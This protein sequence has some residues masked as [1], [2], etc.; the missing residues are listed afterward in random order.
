MR[1]IDKADVARIAVGAAVL[2]TGGGGDPA[3]GRLMAEAAIDRYGPVQLIGVDEVPDDAWV[4]PSSGMGAPTVSIEKLPSWREID[5]S[6]DDAQVAL[7]AQPFATMPIEIGGANALMPLALAARRGI[8]M[9]D[10]DAMG[11]AFPESQMVSFALDGMAS[12]FVCIAD[13]KGNRLT[14]RPV[15]AVWQEVL[16]RPVVDRMGASAMVCDFPVTGVEL[17]RSGLADTVTLAQKI[18][19]ALLDPAIHRGNP[20]GALLEHTRGHRLLTGK[21][22]DLDRTTSGGFVRG[23]VTLDGIDADK[24]RRIV[25]RFQNEFLLAEENGRPRAITP[26]LIALL[27]RDSALPWT[28]ESLRY[29]MRVHVVA[30][31]CHDKWRTPAGI[32]T[33]G[34]GYFGYATAYTP[35]E[36]LVLR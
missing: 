20:L 29:G 1:L 35:I 3:I 14:M 15:D 31:P 8:P 22:V 17:R 19:D 7:G 26:D 4:V 2:G 12:R 36:Q 27:D 16:S 28:T 32:A 30:M 18:G 23:S 5:N 25:I 21:I 11:R 34:P 10:V 33:A 24:G 9:V 6:F 13:E